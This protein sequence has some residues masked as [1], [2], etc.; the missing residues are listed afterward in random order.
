MADRITVIGW[1]GTPLTEAAGAA[2]AAATL[3]AGAPYQL[4]ALP[5]PEDAERITLGNI[6]QAARTIAERIAAST[7]SGL[8][9]PQ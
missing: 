4:D 2:L 6:G 5:V 7:R 1:D 3:V 8:A 9:E